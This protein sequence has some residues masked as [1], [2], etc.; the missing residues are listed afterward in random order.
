M[1]FI[2]QQTKLYIA[3]SKLAFRPGKCTVFRFI[4]ITLSEYE[5][6]MVSCRHGE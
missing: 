1:K 5:R 4:I 2:N 6:A 3:S